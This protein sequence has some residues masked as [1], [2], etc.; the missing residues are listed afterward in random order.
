[1]LSPQDIQKLQSTPN[2]MQPS[3]SQNL[4]DTSFQNWLKPTDTSSASSNGVG[5]FVKSLISAPATMLAR[6]V[7]AAQSAGQELGSNT[8]E[9]SKISEQGNESV[10]NLISLM[11]EKQAR[12]EDVSHIQKTLQ[13]IA[14]TPNAAGNELENQSSYKPSSGGIIAPAPENFKDVK[15]DV[16]RGIETVALGVGSPVAGGAAF[17]LGNSLE[18]GNDLFSGQTAFQTVLGGGAG[19]ILGLIGEPIMNAAGKTIGKITPDFLSNIASQG[20]K[21]IQDFAAAHDILPKVASD[22]VNGANDAVTGAV[23]KTG[24]AIK[25]TVIGTPEEIVSKKGGKALQSSIQD[26]MPLQSKD[27]RIDELRNSLPDN[28]NGGVKREGILGKS[29]PQPTTEDIQRGTIAHDY[30]NGEKDPV[31][32][33]QNVNKGIQDISNDTDTFLDKNSAPANFEDMRNYMESNRP[34]QSLQKDP[35]ASES[36]NRAT[37]NALDTLN[38]TMKDSAKT[39]GDYGPTTSGADIRKARIAIDKQ[40]TAELGENAF[41]TP[42]YKGIKAAEI[43]TRNLLNRMSEDMLRYP[44]Q[45]ENLNKMNEF[46]SAAKGRGIDIDMENPEVKAQLEKRFGL[47]STS[48]G[49]SNAQKLADQ[50]SKMSSLYEARDNMIDKYQSNVGKNK[51]QEFIKNNPLKTKVAKI[52]AGIVGVGA[53]GELGKT[54]LGL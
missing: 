50:H 15:K 39:S 47:E 41:G 30:I 40:I 6:P 11:H 36:Y 8:D 33:I 42:Q 28:G 21:A 45:L 53:A 52:G 51:V 43:D 29:T 38:K 12:G 46:V 16:G 48:E 24:Q 4:D 18:Q 23:D 25:D 17:G 54:A 32:K 37:E 31:K 1:M 26:T 20:T 13:D 2:P 49:E 3:G 22:A 27:V 7:Q 19:K 14:Q 44:G 9:L 10:K 35:G 5:D 34:S